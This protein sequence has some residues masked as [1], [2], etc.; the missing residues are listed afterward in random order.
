[1]KGLLGGTGVCDGLGAWN[2]GGRGFLKVK[3]L[4]DHTHGR[5]GNCRS[6]SLGGGVGILGSGR[7]RRAGGGAFLGGIFAFGAILDHEA[8][9]FLDP[10][11]VV[12]LGYGSGGLVDP[13]MLI[14]VNVAGDLVLTLRV[15]DDFL[16]FQ[17]QPFTIFPF[18]AVFGRE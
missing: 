11:P 7:G 18:V 13:A 5:G 10:N 1:M 2:T 16:V 14:C 6:L 3:E 15:T 12:L 8:D 17:H 4:T 9:G